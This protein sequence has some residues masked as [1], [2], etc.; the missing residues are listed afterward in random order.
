MQ[1]TRDYSHFIKDLGAGR[2]HIDLAVEGVNCAGCM[3]KIERGLSAMPDVTLA[4][5]NLTDRRV[6]LEWKAGALDPSNFIDRLAELG[7]KAYPFRAADAETAEAEQSRFLLRCLGVAAF[8]TM[9][10]MMLSVPVWFGNVGDMLPEQRD[11]FHWLSALIALPAAAYAGQPFFQSAYRALRKRNVNMDVPISIG[12]LLALGMSLVETVNHAE[13]AYFDAAIMLLTFLLVGRYLDQSMRRKTRAVAGNLAALKAETAT[14]FVGGNE[15]AEV[16]VAAIDPGDIVLLRPGERCAID[17]TVIDGRSE[18]DQSLVTG[19]TTPAR[20]ES[21]TVVYAGSLNISGTLRIRVSAVSEGTLL[22]EI[23]RLLDNA[24]QARSRYIRLA[25]RVSRLYAPVVHATAL[26]TVLGWVLLG[27]SWHDAIVT[28]V[29]VLIITCPCALGLAIPT[30]QTVASGAMFKAGILLNSGDAIERVADVDHVI[31]DKTGTLTLP[32]LEVVNAT[33]IPETL[34]RLA[35]QLALASHH[36]AAAAVARAANAKAPLLGATE[37]AGQG[38]RGAVDGMEARLGRPSFCG[39]EQ[40]ASVQGALDPEASLVGFSFGEE[41]YVFSVRQAL[42]RDA[43]A[44]ISE[45]KKRNIAVEILSGD[46]EPAVRSAASA[47]AVEAWRAGVTPADKIGRIE[48]LKRSGY[49]VMM[50]GDGLNDAPSLAAA[51]VSMSPISAAHLSQATADLVF[52]GK[53]LAPVVNAIDFSRKALHLMRQNL[54][55]AVGY[56][57]LA[58]PIAISGLVTPLIAAA[59]MSGSSLLVML[60]ALRARRVAPGG[61]SWK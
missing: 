16:P 56:N 57:V 31:F 5:V 14:K 25:E 3:S 8:A 43:R 28:G 36:P 50:V 4:R 46:R 34:L 12:V 58:V 20:A 44:M 10:V 55:L 49:K 23:T 19:E 9:N 33:D 15:I 54:W 42:R 47:V 6:A 22:S 40:L 41:K 45:L 11:F 39:V 35:G 2:Q 48:E 27:A 32:D 59:A 17:G 30:V 18:I 53:P 21:G 26:L 29:A 51:H 60:N 38:V 7:Y 24:L 13:H 52:L 61:R 1:A 37:E